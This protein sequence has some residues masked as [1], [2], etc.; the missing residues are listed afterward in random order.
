MVKYTR[1]LYMLL[2][3]CAG[4]SV[5]PQIQTSELT[6]ASVSISVEAQTDAIVYEKK[7]EYPLHAACALGDVETV[8]SL[9][10]TQSVNVNLQD[11]LD[12]LPLWYAINYNRVEIVA[13]LIAAK[14]DVN[15]LFSND[16]HTALTLAIAKGEV[17]IVRMLIAAGAHVNRIYNDSFKYSPLVFAIMYGQ[18]EIVQ[19]LIAA[20]ADV[21]QLCLGDSLSPLHAAIEY[22]SL[23]MVKLLIASGADVNLNLMCQLYSWPEFSNTPLYS[24]SDRGHVEIVKELLAA[25]ADV[26]ISALDI[27]SKNGHLEVV[28]TL[29]AYLKKTNQTTQTI[30]NKALF[31]AAV[32]GFVQIAKELIAAGAQVTCL[33][34]LWYYNF[35][36]Q[37]HEMFDLLIS[38]AASANQ[39]AY[40]NSLLHD[41]CC[42]YV[43]RAGTPEMVKVLITHGADL[44]SLDDL[45]RT[46]L[47]VAVAYHST[48]IVKLLID[49]GADINRREEFQGG[50]TSLYYAIDRENLENV[51]L[52]IAAGADVNQYVNTSCYAE[53]PLCMAIK[54]NCPEIVT[55]LIAAGADVNQYVNTSCYAE[56][57]LYMASRNNLTE[58]VTVLIAAGAQVNNGGT[59]GYTP[60]YIASSIGYVATIE[61]LIKGGADIN[62]GGAPLVGLSPLGIAQAKNQY[63]VVR[64]LKAAGA[65][66]NMFSKL[67]VGLTRNP[68]IFPA[69]LASIY[70][71]GAAYILS[72]INSTVLSSHLDSGFKSMVKSG[73]DAIRYLINV[74]KTA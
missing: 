44:N 2:S 1:Y 55:V 74:V 63:E 56:T 58:I 42:H 23:E 36:G 25:G 11:H 10:A 70:I 13:L 39:K 64:I 69:L 27:A 34:N 12:K 31:N 37:N 54:R 29:I 50:R 32:G 18:V 53:T 72:D 19:L 43:S 73:K 21:N 5:A 8:R 62:K 59:C 15:A 71:A 9:L 35:S 14:V 38:S 28:K 66:E 40:I 51:K 6:K 65:K 52:L 3:L 17:D 48:E 61:A 47:H 45:G 41:V 24:A 46:P 67:K 22:G 30:Y 68:E 33:E 16:R 7:H 26:H 60:L 57:P 49:A 4:L 20:H